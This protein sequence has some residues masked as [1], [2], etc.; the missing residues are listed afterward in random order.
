VVAF[1]ID[2]D[3]SS[4]PLRTMA[5]S[6]LESV[7]LSP[8]MTA[9]SGRPDIGIGLIDGPV[10]VRHP[11]LAHDRLHQLTDSSNCVDETSAACGHGTFVAG[12]LSG[13]R[14]SMAPAIC[15][16]C[17]LVIRPIFSEYLATRTQM[18]SASP[19]VLA[20][21]IVD[22]VN[23]GVRVINLSSSLTQGVARGEMLLTRALDY[24]ARKAVII[25]AA[26]GN[27]GSVGST[28]ITRHRCVIPVA[29]CGNRARPLEYS[30]LGYSIA[31][32]G[33]SAPGEAI[34]SLAPRGGQTSFSGT[35]VAA[36][37]VTGA[38]ALLWA[39][40]PSA[41]SSE[42]RRAVL[43]CS[44]RTRNTIVPPLL[45]AWGAYLTMR[46]SFYEAA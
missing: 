3:G 21:A 27:Q 33:L 6:Q 40:F 39:L 34:T 12:M 25:V 20:S 44:G 37:F 24:A 42:I 8:L 31:R 14:S 46:E 15:P 28:P 29:A 7:R 11:D 19:E 45:D 41:K 32:R 16:E 17:T 9:T 23:A 5:N 35:S 1:A 36:P 10:V 43:S 4:R 2:H 22:C 38:L 18:P 26:A 30:N 13:R